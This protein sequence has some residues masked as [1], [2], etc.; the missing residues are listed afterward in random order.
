MKGLEYQLKKGKKLVVRGIDK[1]RNKKRR[2]SYRQRLRKIQEN[3]P[4][5]KTKKNR[6]QND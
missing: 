3:N 5:G 4:H 2:K 1:K 6:D